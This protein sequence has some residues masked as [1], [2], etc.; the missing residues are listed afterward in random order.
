M[1]IKNIK[2]ILNVEKIAQ[3]CKLIKV[4]RMNENSASFGCQMLLINDSNDT[5]AR[6]NFLWV[7]IPRG[8]INDDLPHI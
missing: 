6:K 8:D 7:I 2:L 4:R 1:H 3:K 5:G